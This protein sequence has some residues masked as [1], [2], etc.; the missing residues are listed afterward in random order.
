MLTV[1]TVK[2]IHNFKFRGDG[3]Y[4]IKMTM[5]VITHCEIF[6]AR[7]ENIILDSFFLLIV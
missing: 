3:N 6:F 7:R 4:K 2:D 1:S 5:F